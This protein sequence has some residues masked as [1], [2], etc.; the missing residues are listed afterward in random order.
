MKDRYSLIEDILEVG[1]YL[2]IMSMFL[3]KGEAVRNILIF[4]NFALWLLTLKERKDLHLL[5]K[6]VS[7][8]FWVYTGSILLSVVFS[9][10]P[11]YSFFELRNEPLKPVLLFPVIAT[12]MSDEKRLKRVAHVMFF[13]SIVIVLI[14]Y[15]SYFFHE[16]DVLKP[17]TAIMHA[18]HNKFAR[19]LNTLLPFSFILYF[20]WKRPALRILLFL[21]ICLSIVALILSTSRGGYLSFFS[22]VVIWAL[23]LSR[24]KGIN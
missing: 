15:Y 23:F 7:V 6:P 5:I 9:I 19:Y 13:T 24:K 8:L 22:I 20:L 18:W 11:T 1:I 16:I 10:D 12:V 3:S 4:G 17:D 21:S 14:G 2:F